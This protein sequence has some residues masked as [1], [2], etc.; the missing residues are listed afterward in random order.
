MTTTRTQKPTGSTGTSDDLAPSEW[1]RG[2]L[3]IPLA[4]FGQSL[5]DPDL[6][7][8]LED[9][10]QRNGETLGD[11]E[12]TA[13]GELKIMAPTGLPGDWYEA[14]VVVEVGIW[15]REHGGKYGG[16]TSLFVLPDGSRLGPDA[17]WM[18]DE[19]WNALPEEARTPPYARVVPDFVVEIVSPSNRGP[20][21][22]D[23]VRRYL[24]VGARL[25]WVIHPVDRTVSV[26]SPG[27]EPEV[28]ADPETVGG[29]D[30]LPGFV[31]N[32]RQRIFDNLP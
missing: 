17:W 27:A 10:A 6:D 19:R 13:K 4:E 20:Q 2:Y 30:V 14:E 28:L 3:L 26:F 18:S 24:D 32:V 29:G 15:G 22:A 1:F 9:F 8:W 31:F 21:L 16:S 11:F 23:K 7:S 25:V 5:D 12:V